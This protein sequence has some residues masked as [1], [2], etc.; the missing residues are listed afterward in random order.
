M[1]IPSILHQKTIQERIEFHKVL[2]KLLFDR[3]GLKDQNLC[4]VSHKN[5]M[6][7]RKKYF[8]TRVII[9]ETN[10]KI[11]FKIFGRL[12]E[13]DSQ[14]A[15]AHSI[16]FP[17]E[18]NDRLKDYQ[19]IPASS[20][21]LAMKIIPL[22][23]DES[24][25]LYSKTFG[26]WKEIEILKRVSGIVK[27]KICPNLPI[28]V[29]SSL[30]TKSIKSEY[31]NKNI[32]TNFNRQDLIKK[33]ETS[34]SFVEKEIT[35]YEK[36]GLTPKLKKEIVKA[37]KM[38]K[39]I[40]K[41]LEK[42]TFN[43]SKMTLMVFSEI[44]HYDLYSWMEIPQLKQETNQFKCAVFQT[45]AGLYALQK[46]AYVIHFD[47]HL[48]NV[49]ITNIIPGGTY[50]YIIDKSSYYIPIYGQLFK[51]WDFGRSNFFKNPVQV[52]EI[53]DN[54][55]KQY[56]YTI[57]HHTIKGL[58]N[59]GKNIKNHFSKALPFVLQFDLYRFLKAFYWHCDE[60]GIKI[61]G[62][63]LNDV[64]TSY[65]NT[66]K[67]FLKLTNDKISSYPKYTIPYIMKILFSDF[68]NNKDP[69]TVVHEVY[70]L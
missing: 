15:E 18:Y 10:A 6:I 63:F 57:K 28:F 17:F 7:S 5:N 37:T 58:K 16:C 14:D 69:E 38:D 64:K 68:T 56:M 8:R 11:Y 55:Q 22:T 26:Q 62:S 13:Y 2:H 46:Y 20:V 29:H 34:S 36:Y 70:K 45:L 51:V 30:C 41:K 42:I 60:L 43:Y 25:N 59:I 32:A 24:H 19:C 4:M 3:L 31:K 23:V 9:D 33:L 40:V 66:K 27:S 67:E 50:H 39:D 35:N 65:K 53:I 12:G 47:L 48:S 52:D 61:N 21:F 1:S 54:A 44:A 49:L